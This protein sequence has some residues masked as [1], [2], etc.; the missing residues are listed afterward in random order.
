MELINFTV[1][2][3]KCA[4]DILASTWGGLHGRLR[5]ICSTFVSPEQAPPVKASIYAPVMLAFTGG[6]CPGDC[7]T[8]TINSD[9]K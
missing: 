1:V 7:G 3:V 6:A 8:C 2:P 9:G 4:T 5:Y